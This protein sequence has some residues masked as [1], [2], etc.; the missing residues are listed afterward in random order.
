MDGRVILAD[1][2]TVSLRRTARARRMTLRVS[3]RDGSVTLTLPPRLPRAEA[4]AF[5]DDR[6]DWLSRALAGIE[7]QQVIE[8]GIGLPVEGRPL[9]LTPAQVRAPRVEDA[10]LLLPKGRPAAVS[11]GAFLRTLAQARLAAASDRHAAVLGRR[12]AAITLRDTRSRW[13]SC[14]H[15]GRLMYSWRLAMAPPEVLDYVAAH[16][17]AHL[18]HMDH[19]AA[20]W[21]TVTRLYPGFAQPRAWLRQNGASLH[22]W[23]FRAE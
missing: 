16:E 10:L 9:T 13:G 22:A 17:V 11:A 8:F 7:P 14:T 18:A 5:L 3:R 19:S 12:F 6:R 4:L 21:A 2:T 23:R 1:G 15:G 20:F